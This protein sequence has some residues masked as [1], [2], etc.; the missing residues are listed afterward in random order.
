[1]PR[2]PVH[3]EHVDR[4]VLAPGTTSSDGVRVARIVALAA[5][6]TQNDA[7]KAWM[8]EDPHLTWHKKAK[9]LLA[10]TREKAASLG[11]SEE[12]ADYEISVVLAM[13]A[14][15]GLAKRGKR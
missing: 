11:I 4:M 9:A 5:D 15:K 6:K 2:E 3:T 14:L 13:Q 7:A 1:M 10:D 8:N 12:R